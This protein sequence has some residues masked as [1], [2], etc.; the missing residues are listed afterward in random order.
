MNP[1]TLV[2]T[3]SKGAAPIGTGRRGIVRAA[4]L[5]AL[6]LGAAPAGAQQA[7]VSPAEAL[8]RIGM[9]LQQHAPNHKVNLRLAQH[10]YGSQPLQ[11][12]QPVAPP[13][14]IKQLHFDQQL[15]SGGTTT[16]SR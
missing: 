2:R 13:Q 7:D 4:F 9:R 15:L 8:E 3:R 16:A 1:T 10:R 6:S 14:W 5:L 11:R 12:P